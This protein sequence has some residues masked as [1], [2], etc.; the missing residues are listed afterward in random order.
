MNTLPPSITASRPGPPGQPPHEAGPA[1]SRD[2]PP[3]PIGHVPGT[4]TPRGSLVRGD[5]RADRP[6]F[7]LTAR[8]REVAEALVA[9]R[10]PDAGADQTIIGL[11]AALGVLTV[12]AMCFRLLALGMLPAPHPGDAPALDPLTR[13]VWGA[14]RWDILDADFV[15]AVAMGLCHGRGEGLRLWTRVVEDALDRLTDRH[16]TTRHGLI[17]IGFAHGVLSGD[18]SVSSPAHPFPAPTPPGVGAWDASP[19]QRRALAMRASGR[20]TAACAVAD[21]T[22]VNAVTGRLSLAK[23]MAGDVRTHRALIHRALGDGVLQRPP[24]KRDDTGLSKQERAVWRHFALDVPDNALASRIG[25]HTGLGMTI[26]HRCLSTL[27][28]RYRD[29]CAVVYEGWRYGVLDADT[30]TDLTCCTAPGLSA[31]ASGGVR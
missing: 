13:T 19:A 1:L 6:A 8:Q 15:P 31:P 21:G 14:L 23:K 27:R 30:P 25:T 3:Y 26:V 20:A 28:R 18:Q 2:V 5:Q 4:A 29:D 16:A 12:R 9:G 22:T 7:S 24:L 17:R 10:A 11:Q